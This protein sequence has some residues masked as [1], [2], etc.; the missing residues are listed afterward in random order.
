MDRVGHS[1][2]IF[3]TLGNHEE[4]EGWNL[5]DTPSRAVLNIQARKA[6]FPTPTNDGFYSGNVRSPDEHRRDG[7]R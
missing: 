7:V 3:L 5:D 6:F 2:P 1:V 4:E